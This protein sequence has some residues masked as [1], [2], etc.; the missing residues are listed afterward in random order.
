M[1]N[2]SEIGFIPTDQYLFYIYNE[3]YDDMSNDDKFAYCFLINWLIVQSMKSQQILTFHN[4]NVL[5]P[6][7]S[8]FKLIVLSNQ[9]LQTQMC[10]VY[11]SWSEMISWNWDMFHI[12]LENWLIIKIAAGKFSVDQI[13]S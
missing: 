10:S 2:G 8:V 13:I 3:T 5:N 7:F 11:S 9:K 12:L 1:I 6:K 4:H